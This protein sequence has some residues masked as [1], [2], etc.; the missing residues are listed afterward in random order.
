MNLA[1]NPFFIA[2]Q[3]ICPGV[4]KNLKSFWEDNLAS[5]IKQIWQKPISC[6]SP[7]AVQARS[8]FYDALNQFFD[9]QSIDL[10][11][12]RSEFQRYPILQTGPHCPLYVN[13]ID[14][15]AVLFSWMGSQLHHIKHALILNSMTRTVQW[16]KEQG[17]GWL[18][19]RYTNIKLFD[20]SPKTMSKLSVCSPVFHVRYNK[21]GFEHYLKQITTAEQKGLEKLGTVISSRN[22]ENFICLFTK[23]NQDL[24]AGCDQA[25]EVKPLIINDRL[26]ALLVA[27]H[28]REQEGII[29][30]LIFSPKKRNQLKQLIEDLKKEKQHLFLKQRTDYF[31]GVRDNRIRA[32]LIEGDFLKEDSKG[33]DKQI[34]IPLK[35]HSICKALAE[36]QLIPN[37]FLSM[38]VLGLMPQI[39]LLGGT[40]QIAYLP[41]IQ[42]VFCALLDDKIPQE[43]ALKQELLSNDLNAWGTNFIRHERTPLECLG[44]LPAGKEYS[45]LGQYYLNHSLSYLTQSL[46][47]FKE[48]PLWNCMI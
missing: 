18:N 32:L 15:N 25:Q 26:T 4:A 36:G 24:L 37:I 42:R 2:M 16:S 5:Y 29:Y 7:L 38:L 34:L 21:N 27:E 30:Q 23:T 6:S 1:L 14:F 19:L 44:H 9:S 33:S 47:V 46:S 39:R 20:L 31:W 22:Y 10:N 35:A 3:G 40:R 13:E 28:I 17:P 43:R 11:Q 41:L 8:K 48:H 45:L 12:V